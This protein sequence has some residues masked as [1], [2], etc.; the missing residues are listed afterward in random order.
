MSKVSV[1]AAKAHFSEILAQVE[2]GEE[3]LITRRGA[4]VARLSGLQ[5]PRIPPDLD[6]IDRLRASLP[7]SQKRSAVL[8]RRMRDSDY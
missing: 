6:A 3:V 4:P 8:L 7:L 1:V 5:R 2:A